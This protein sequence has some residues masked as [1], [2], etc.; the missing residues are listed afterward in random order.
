MVFIEV[1][2]VIVVYGV[3]E[4]VFVSVKLCFDEYVNVEGA[5]ATIFVALGMD[6]L[7]LFF[8]EWLV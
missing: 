6:Y 3:C 7:D 2:K 1:G 4:S 5:F 8:I